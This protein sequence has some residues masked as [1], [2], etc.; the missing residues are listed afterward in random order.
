MYEAKTGKR[1]KRSEIK[2]LLLLI[3]IRREGPIGRYRLKEMLDLSEREGLVRLMLSDLKHE[4]C[5]RTGKSGSELTGKGEALLGDLFKK[6]EILNVKEMNL[7]AL[8]I[9]PQSFV[10]HLHGHKI[11]EPVVEL[12]DT[13]VKAGASGAVLLT[14]EKGALT[15]PTV[16]SDLALEHPELAEKILKNFDLSEGDILV[17]GFSNNRWRALEGCL[18]VIMFL[19]KLRI[20]ENDDSLD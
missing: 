20:N 14:Y 5:I 3:M 12:R 2:F 10:I 13:A 1:K 7:K 4:G 18:A 17:V 6:Y 11:P 16:Y 8:G 19:S 15:V 9:G